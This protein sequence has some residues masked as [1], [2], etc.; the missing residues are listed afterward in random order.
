ML[1]LELLA[2]GVQVLQ[3]SVDLGTA[4]AELELDHCLDLCTELGRDE[5]GEFGV[6]ILGADLSLVDEDGLQLAPV[7][8]AEAPVADEIGV[9][10]ALAVAGHLHDQAG[11]ADPATER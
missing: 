1:S 2:F 5:S 9:E 10:R 4:V 11:A 8:L 7:L 3:R 6:M